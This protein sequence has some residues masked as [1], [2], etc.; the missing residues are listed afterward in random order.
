MIVQE[1]L[2]A[3]YANKVQAAAACFMHADH[4]T[5][6]FAQMG[7]G[8]AGAVLVDALGGAGLRVPDLR[9][10]AR[11]VHEQGQLLAVDNTVPS[12]FGCNPFVLGADVALEALDRVA[13]GDLDSK[14]VA[15]SLRKG[16]RLEEAR[17]ESD[18]LQPCDLD[19]IACG[20]DSMDARMQVHFD[21]ARALAEYLRCV[22]GLASVSY[23]G[24]S[25]HPD[26]GIAA[27]T[28]MHGFG[29][30]LDFELPPEWGIHADEFIASCR[31]NGRT[32]PAGGSHTRLH[33]RDGADGLAVRI[34]AGLD[35]P[36]AIAD[37][38][39]SAFR[40]LRSR[41]ITLDTVY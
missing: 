35:D 24:C 13:A 10:K 4:V 11:E 16:C 23:P 5:A 40:T 18:A 15:V 3:R 36:L 12:S 32:C 38:L 21:H 20:L 33:A 1:E 28:L 30:A 2:E 37:D 26:H 19:A 29:P 17:L 39:D 25:N 41:G 9:A 31:L 7:L 8:E 27:R 6:A 22:D 14:V 34:F